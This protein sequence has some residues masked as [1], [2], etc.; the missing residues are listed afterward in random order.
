MR[1][2]EEPQLTQVLLEMDAR[3]IDPHSVIEFIGGVAFWLDGNLPGKRMS[4]V[5]VQNEN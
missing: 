3:E 4:E 5:E 1:K 2:L